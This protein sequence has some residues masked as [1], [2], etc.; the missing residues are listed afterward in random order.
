MR[1]RFASA[2]DC[3]DC[4]PLLS[5]S[6]P[7][8]WPADGIILCC[9]TGLLLVLSGL[10]VRFRCVSVMVGVLVV[11]LG[12]LLSSPWLFAGPVCTGSGEVDMGRGLCLLLCDCVPVS[13]SASLLLFLRASLSA[14]SAAH[15]ASLYLCAS[16]L[17][18]PSFVAAADVSIA[19]ARCW[20]IARLWLRRVKWMSPL[21]RGFP[22][23]ALAFAILV[24][25]LTPILPA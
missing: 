9:C 1:A 25:I 4:V 14:V 16:N 3:L 12:C 7:S 2:G 11:S 17:D 22:P 19:V 13:V 5:I 10:I 21:S 20:C 15:M 6:G 18:V 24:S 23:P 8:P